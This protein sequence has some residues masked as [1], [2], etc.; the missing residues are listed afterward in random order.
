MQGELK[1]PWDV[2]MPL[3]NQVVANCDN[4][5]LDLRHWSDSSGDRG[6]DLFDYLQDGVRIASTEQSGD[7]E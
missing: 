1:S 6:E 5:S 4:W 7:W 3:V 2:V